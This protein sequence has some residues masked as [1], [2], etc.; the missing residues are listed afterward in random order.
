MA[1]ALEEAE[2]TGGEGAA[3]EAAQAGGHGAPVVAA[4]QPEAGG[5]G[6]LL[7][8]SPPA[9]V[10]AFGQVAVQQQQQVAAVLAQQLQ[11]REWG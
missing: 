6:A 9:Q 10:P 5:V 2:Q 1:A 11:Q 3:V 8:D 4:P 7:D